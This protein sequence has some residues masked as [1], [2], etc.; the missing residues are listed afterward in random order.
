MNMQEYWIIN[1]SKKVIV[2]E[3]LN[4]LVIFPGINYNILKK[5]NNISTEMIEK[6]IKFGD[7]LKKSKFI[8]I[9]KQNLSLI[10]AKILLAEASPSTVNISYEEQKDDNLIGIGFEEQNFSDEKFVED[11]LNAEEDDSNKIIK[12]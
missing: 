1:I 6:S 3:D 5:S 2:L 7:L 9:G 12:K 8:K 4:D 10:K 11:I